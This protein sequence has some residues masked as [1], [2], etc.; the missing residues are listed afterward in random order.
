MY[1]KI[2]KFF[3]LVRIYYD[4]KYAENVAN[5]YWQ[6]TTITHGNMSKDSFDFYYKELKKII[7]PKTT[8]I[9]LDYGGGN[10]EIAHRFKQD[11]YKIDHYD[12]SYIMQENAR[13]LFLLS[14]LNENEL[15]SKKEY[16][17]IILFNNGFFYIHPKNQEKVLRLLYDLLKVNGKLFITDTPDYEKRKIINGEKQI[18]LYM[19]IT[20]FFPVYQIDLSG[21]WIKDKDIKKKAFNI[22]F[23]E[24]KKIDSWC[25]YRS[26]WILEK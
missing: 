16:Y 9:I 1:K 19:I 13:K 21:F 24:V 23:K 15:K 11:G 7:N 20:K 5:K 25:D 8:D 3:K 22:G 18:F 14:S 10:G 17:D 6:N 2:L 4:P 26:H 12:I